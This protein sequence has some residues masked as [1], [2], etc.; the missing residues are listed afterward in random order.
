MVPNR[1]LNIGEPWSDAHPRTD[2]PEPLNSA[3]AAVF[4]GIGATLMMFVGAEEPKAFQRGSGAED[5]D[6]PQVVARRV[7]AGPHMAR[8]PKAFA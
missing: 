4:S 1:V 8:L 7:P 3:I 2:L 6:S 5:H